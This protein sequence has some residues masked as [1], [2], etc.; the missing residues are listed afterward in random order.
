MCYY[1]VH[2][3]FTN[4]INVYVIP[5]DPRKYGPSSFV[6]I[7]EFIYD[8]AKIILDLY[9]NIVTRIKGIYWNI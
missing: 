4:L 9:I 2:F 7:A 6:I 1:C 8:L 5:E 3:G